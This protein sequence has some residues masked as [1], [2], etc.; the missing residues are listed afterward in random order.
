MDLRFQLKKNKFLQ[1]FPLTS[2]P[3][4]F[5]PATVPAKT[6]FQYLASW[7]G[8]RIFLFISSIYKNLNIGSHSH[9]SELRM[10]AASQLGAISKK[11]KAGNLVL[12]SFSFLQYDLC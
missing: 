1:M 12:S 5:Y 9:I 10:T 3:L 4:I 11:G 6:T 7:P 8:S 2:L